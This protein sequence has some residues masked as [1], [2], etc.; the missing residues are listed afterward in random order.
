VIVAVKVTA[1]PSVDVAEL[2]ATEA[3]VGTLILME[4]LC[5]ASGPKNSFEALTVPVYVPGVV[6][7]P[8][9]SPL[10]DSDRPG[11]SAPAVTANAGRG[12][13]VAE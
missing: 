8:D 11:G 12:E 5:V 4:K 10:S 1:S 6:G 9:S 2:G 13:P 3:R 7:V